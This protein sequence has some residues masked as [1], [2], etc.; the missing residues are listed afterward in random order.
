MGINGAPGGLTEIEVGVIDELLDV[1]VTNPSNGEF[2]TYQNG[3][4]VNGAGGA[5]TGTVTSVSAGGGLTASTN[6]ITAA[7]DIS[8]ANTGVSAGTYT[9]STIT[10]NARGQITAASNG[11]SGAGTV[12]SAAVSGGGG[13][14]VAGSPIT[15]EGV[16]SLGL[17]DIT[18][19]TISTSTGTFTGK[20]TGTTAAFS[21]LVSAD[22]GVKATTVSAASIGVTGDINAASGRVLASAMTVTGLLTGATATF[23]GLVSANSGLRATTVSASGVIGGSNL[24]G[25]NTGDQ[26]ITLTGDVSGS[27]TGSFGTVVTRIQGVQVKAGVPAGNTVLTYNASASLW[28]AASAQAGGGAGT[29]TSVSAGGGLTASSNPITTTGDISIADTAVSAGSYTLASITVNSRGQITAASNG[30]AG[31]GTVTSAAVSG[32]NGIVVQG[33]PITTEGVISLS[34][35]DITPRAVTASGAVTGSNLSGTNTGDQTITL[36][37]D[38]SGG[39]TGGFTA[40]INPGAVTNTKLASMAAVTIKSNILSS[41]ATPSDNTLGSIL[42]NVLGSAAGKV[43]YRGAEGWVASALSGTGT[44][45]SVS[46]GAGLTFSTNPI[47]STGDIRLDTSALN[48]WTAQQYFQAATLT[49]ASA[50]SWNLTSQQVAKLTVAGTGTRQLQDPTNMRDGAT[51][52]LAVTKASSQSCTLAWAS[53]YRWPGSTAPTFST[54]SGATDIFTFVCVGSAMYGSYTQNYTAG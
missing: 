32:K 11:A 16:I 2:L 41:A 29:V 53:A 3:Q 37:G 49:D 9:I 15:T 27:G 26:T 30:A 39:G 43:V 22:A 31:S 17:G 46:G 18:P 54:G 45:T 35:L 23:S 13:I 8:I 47:T 1:A 33:S 50:I 12:T 20:V 14:T 42:D 40:T 44:V 4:W 52:I 36:S 34:L 7:G 51:Y 25:T 24:S 5:G 6:P 48:A 28:E 38:V 19:L 10:V 21:G